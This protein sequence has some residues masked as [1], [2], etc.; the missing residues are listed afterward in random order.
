MLHVTSIDLASATWKNRGLCCGLES[1]HCGYCVRVSLFSL[2][3]N[4]TCTLFI[5][6]ADIESLLFLAW[7]NSW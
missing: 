3:D 1:D 6:T 5:L 2:C 4:V 7:W